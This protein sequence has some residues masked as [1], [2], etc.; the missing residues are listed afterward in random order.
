[1]LWASRASSA[2][3]CVAIS[4]TGIQCPGRA[5]KANGGTAAAVPCVGSRRLP[6]SDPQRLP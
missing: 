4:G 6:P 5:A 3:W 1:M 2:M